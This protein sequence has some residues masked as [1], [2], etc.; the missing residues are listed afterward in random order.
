MNEKK[1]KLVYISGKIGETEISPATRRK[2]LKARNRLV[3][4]GYA[5]ID[6]TDEGYQKETKHHVKIE[7]K[8]WMDLDVGAFDWYAWVLLWDMHSLALA[9]AIYMLKDWKDSK[10]AMAEHAFAVACGKEIIY[11]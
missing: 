2:F 6:P 9:D 10:G 4:A 7:K 11:E 1:I 8:K 5:I 3:K